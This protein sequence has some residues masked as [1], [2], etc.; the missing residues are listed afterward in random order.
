MKICKK[1]GSSAGYNS[2][3][4]AYYC[5]KC[6]NL[7]YDDVCSKSDIFKEWQ[8]Y[9]NLEEHGMLLK[10]NAPIDIIIRCAM[11]TNSMRSDRGCDGDCQVDEIMFDRI[12]KEILKNQL[13]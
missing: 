7:D 11:C 3:F 13:K 2:Y 10:L 8:E 9:K 4:K 5:D 12:M 6:G 1:C